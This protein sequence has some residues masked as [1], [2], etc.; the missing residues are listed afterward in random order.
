MTFS[1]VNCAMD[2]KFEQ[3]AAS[4]FEVS[5]VDKKGFKATLIIKKSIFDVDAFGSDRL[6]QLTAVPEFISNCYCQLVFASA[7]S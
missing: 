4:A 5:V 1:V 7:I 6:I 3:Y 2:G